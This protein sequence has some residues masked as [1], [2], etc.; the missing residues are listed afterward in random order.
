MGASSSGPHRS[1]TKAAIQY[2]RR[3]FISRLLGAAAIPIVGGLLT[4]R[5]A[6]AQT[7]VTSG[8]AFFGRIFGHLPPFA[9][10]ANP[11]VRAASLDIGKPLG[12]LDAQDGNIQTLGPFAP[13]L[14]ITDPSLS[15]NNPDNPT[16][17]AGTTFMGQFLDHDMTFDFTSP[18]GVPTQP[19][20]T[21]TS[22]TPAFDLDSVY[23]GGYLATPQFYDP[24]DPVKFRVESGGLFED[25]PRD[26][27]TRAIIP[28]FRNDENLMIAGLHA[29]FLLFHNHAVDYVR[30]QGELSD[31]KEVFAEARRL[32]TWH[33]QW[34]IV[35]EFLPLFV[36]Q[37]MVDD[38][39]ANGPNF[40]SP[41]LRKAFMPVEFQTGTYRM[42]HSMVRP[43][44]RANLKGILQASSA[45]RSSG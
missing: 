40:Y 39:L 37:K 33:Y 13:R 6:V 11:Q 16:H 15:V 23:G 18:L 28:D 29:A 8:P 30:A 42:G 9:D 25:L 17:T 31:P 43:S 20:T 38:V 19:T 10:A 45:A 5:G 2:S 26:A 21:P 24:A 3:Q 44:Y 27:A 14:L 4:P 41:G 22:R 36:G 34:M 1:A 7:T 35:H 12:L 32:T